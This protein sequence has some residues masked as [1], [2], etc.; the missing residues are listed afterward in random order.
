[1]IYK[2]FI[3]LFFLFFS[4]NI[5]SKNLFET[6]QKLINFQDSNINN[7]KD[8]EIKKIKLKNL[9]IILKNV[10]SEND[11]NKIKRE[12]NEDF[13]NS[14][15]KNIIIEDENIIN[16]S[17][18]ANIKVN[19]N[20]KFI[21]NYL[22]KKQLSY[23]EFHPKNFLI[24]VF[25]KNDINKNLFFKK[26][27]FYY[28]LNNKENKFNN[29]YKIPYFDINDKYILSV[30][31]IEKRNFKNINLVKNKYNSKNIILIEQ[32]KVFNTSFLDIF[33]VAENEFINLKSYKLDSI[34]YDNFFIN[35]KL[36]ILFLLEAI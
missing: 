2:L 21:I 36:L 15:I 13:A 4:N 35:L 17:Y 25:E 3:I 27:E 5:F 8:E 12:I 20:K 28:F 23:V 30:E 19:F 24:I 10:L 7:I 31:D 16:N 32:K 1:M 29:F 33:Y 26:N 6:D 11:Y 18:S 34:N 9:N 22:R 14:L